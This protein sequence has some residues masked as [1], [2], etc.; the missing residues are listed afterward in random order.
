MSRPRLTGPDA[1]RGLALIG[2]IAVHVTPSGRPGDP[3]PFADAVA[4]GRASALFAVL[5]GCGL[6]L[7]TGGPT[8]WR[9]RRLSRA[10]RAV[11]ARAGV[12]AAV[13]LT[14]GLLPTP[15]AIILVYYGVLVLVALPVLGWGPRP[16][17]AAATACAAATPVV[18]H[19]LRRGSVRGPGANL[20]WGDAVTDPVGLLR[21]VTLDGYYPVLT[22]STYLLAGLAVGRLPLT[23]ARVAGRLLAGGLAAAA[24]GLLAGAW[25]VVAA[26][27]PAALGRGTG[28]SAAEVTHRLATSSY[29][30]SP[31]QSW[32]WLGT[33]GRHSGT[34][35]DLVHTTGS[36]LAVLG[37]CLLVATAWGRVPAGRRALAPLVAVGSMTLTLYSL[38]VMLLGATADWTALASLPPGLV[39]VGH[40]ALALGIAALSGAPG[41][42]GPLEALAAAA[43]RAAAGPDTVRARAGGPADS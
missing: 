9:G 20:G 10:R 1:A 11:A 39:V 24:A 14:I 33:A 22:W 5:A 35:P 30:T 27:G 32:W 4:G 38:H 12:V 40:V 23:S 37:A 2:M 26:G 6:A 3:V 28:W 19:L 42:R 36:A 43:S 25:S 7:S 31:A 34:G 41:R 21:T 8:P 18:S 16:L 15:A 17:A 29:G 13:G